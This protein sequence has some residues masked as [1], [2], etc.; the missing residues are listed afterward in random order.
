MP[1]FRKAPCQVLRPLN[2]VTPIDNRPN[3]DVRLF[4]RWKLGKRI[5]GER[6]DSPC[7]PL[8]FPEI[9]RLDDAPLQKGEGRLQ[10]QARNSPA[11]LVRKR[12][13]VPYTLEES[14]DIHRKFD[15]D[16]FSSS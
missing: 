4:L 12:K 3:N 16:N 9:G 6:A 7:L 15:I 1:S 8:F 5:A 2:T 11:I 14:Q 13:A 10:Q